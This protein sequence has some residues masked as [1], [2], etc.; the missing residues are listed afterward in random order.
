MADAK[1]TSDEAV[2][3]FKRLFPSVSNDIISVESSKPGSPYPFYH[4][5]FAENQSIGYIDIT[6][7][8]GHVLSF[9]SERPLARKV[10]RLRIFRKRR[11]LF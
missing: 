9:L 5:R 6:E 11:K 3:R 8:G 1:V 7:K 4:I 10:Y 2:D